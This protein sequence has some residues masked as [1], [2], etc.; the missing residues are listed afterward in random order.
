MPAE[1]SAE[2]IADGFDFGAGHLL[3][4]S[5]SAELAHIPSRQDC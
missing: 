2:S 1:Q 4:L 3:I 5:I